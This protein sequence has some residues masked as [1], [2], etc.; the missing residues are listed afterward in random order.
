[1]HLSHVHAIC[2][3]LEEKIREEFGAFD[4]LIHPEPAGNHEPE[5]KA[6]QYEIAKKQEK[7]D[8]SNWFLRKTG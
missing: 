5:T 4:I 3:E 6:A 7:I 8:V 2:D 1:M